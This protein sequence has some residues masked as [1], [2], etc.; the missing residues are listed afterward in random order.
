MC[1][2]TGR[3]DR[4]GRAVKREV[5]KPFQIKE[6]E[7]YV[8]PGSDAEHHVARLGLMKKFEACFPIGR[9]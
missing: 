9:A 2:L 6:E 8:L 1:P 4:S 3:R 5:L 7:V